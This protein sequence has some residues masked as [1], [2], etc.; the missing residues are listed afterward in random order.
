[1]YRI[2]AC[3][4]EAVFLQDMGNAIQQVM[5]E[6]G[7]PHQLALFST[8]EA[9][10]QAV[11]G[12][13]AGYDIIFLDI[14]MDGMDGI[15]LAKEI[16]KHSAEVALVFVT[17]SRDYAL[18]GYGVKALHYLL[19]PVQKEDLAALLAE[20]YKKRRQGHVLVLRG[21]EAMHKVQLDKV[22]YLEYVNRKTVLHTAGDCVSTNTPLS[23]LEKELPKEIFIRCH[24]GYILNLENIHELRRTQAVTVSGFVVPISRGHTKAV[25]SAF[26]KRMQNSW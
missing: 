8:S 16:R 6:Q 26:L 23:Q 15:A 1:M 7:L 11:Q 5:G 2:A 25:Q 3:D 14:V 13:K 19:K 4:D 21:K 24:Q 22:E 20:D 18:E 9:L 10:L 17:A 12:A